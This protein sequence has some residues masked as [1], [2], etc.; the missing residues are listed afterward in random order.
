MINFTKYINEYVVRITKDYDDPIEIS[1]IRISDSKLVKFKQKWV[2]VRKL[3]KDDV[4]DEDFV[5]QLE[6]NWKHDESAIKTFLRYKREE[7]TKPEARTQ[8]QKQTKTKKCK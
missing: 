7:K 8:N 4:R 2:L 6:N 3:T 1:G 5:D